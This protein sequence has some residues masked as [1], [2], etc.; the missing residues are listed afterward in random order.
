MTMY[1]RAYSKYYDYVYQR[2]NYRTTKELQLI[3]SIVRQTGSSPD[4]CILDVGCGT[5]R[6]LLP[7]TLRGHRV[8]GLDKSAWMLECLKK[9]SRQQNIQTG[10]LSQGDFLSHKFN[11]VYSGIYC[12]FNTFGIIAPSVDAG[13]KAA[14]KMRSLVAKG[15]WILIE[16]N[17]PRKC[18]RDWKKKLTGNDKQLR[19]E[20]ATDWTQYDDV[21]GH[22]T[23]NEE[24][25]VYRK[26]DQ[27][28]LLRKKG[29]V[30][31]KMWTAD[32][33]KLLFHSVKVHH[34]QIIGDDYR[35]G[36]KPKNSS[37]I[38]CLAII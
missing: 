7:L 29:I 28:L 11:R 9:K 1:N 37:T 15:G 27:K 23:L 6:H 31:L 22:L 2:I 10:T 4:D 3:E 16:M 26:N 25:R 24:L 35:L 36:R 33:L 20:E 14:K 13:M 19:V 5:G 12:F 18:F 17:N 34:V 21:T 38:I 30:R 32:E 8:D